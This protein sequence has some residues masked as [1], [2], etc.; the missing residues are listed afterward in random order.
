MSLIFMILLILSTILLHYLLYFFSNRHQ[1]FEP[2][3]NTISAKSDEETLYEF[4]MNCESGATF[5]EIKNIF[6]KLQNWEE[7]L[8]LYQILG[9]LRSFPFCLTYKGKFYIAKTYKNL[10]C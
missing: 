8:Q 5:S 10:F 3:S 4:L 1:N 6:P 9:F 2:D 7:P